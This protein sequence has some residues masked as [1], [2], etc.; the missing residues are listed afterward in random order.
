MHF[1]AYRK[2]TR[3]STPFLLLLQQGGWLTVVIMNMNY[4]KD[5]LKPAESICTAC[6]N[7]HKKPAQFW[8]CIAVGEVLMTYW[9]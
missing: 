6:C 5:I 7:R 3:R 2:E 9:N 4:N 1:K 8:L